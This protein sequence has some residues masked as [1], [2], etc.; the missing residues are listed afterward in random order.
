MLC[1]KCIDHRYIAS[2]SVGGKLTRVK[3]RKL[4]LAYFYKRST[5][6]MRTRSHKRLVRAGAIEYISIVKDVSM[7][8]FIA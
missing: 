5:R 7:L 8:I 3:T 6:I 4:V 2:E 1:G